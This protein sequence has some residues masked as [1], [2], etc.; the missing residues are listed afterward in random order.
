LKYHRFWAVVFHDV[1]DDWLE[2]GFVGFVGDTI[3]EWEIDRVVL[4]SANTDIPKFACAGKVLAILVER[5]R[6]DSVGGIKGL[7]D[8]VAMVN[9]NVYVQHA[10]LVTEELNDSK[11]NVWR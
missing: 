10:L 8:T 1:R 3:S 2:D 11:D 9:I 5:A 7:L 4:S 6:H